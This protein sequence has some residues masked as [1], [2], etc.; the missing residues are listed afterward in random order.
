MALIFSGGGKWT[1][2]PT[3]KKTYQGQSKN[4][5][6]CQRGRRPRRKL[7]RGQGR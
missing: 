5:K 7:R 4:S 2:L 6:V 1:V 3:E